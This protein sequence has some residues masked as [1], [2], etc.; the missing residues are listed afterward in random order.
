MNSE[1]ILSDYLVA[2][3]KTAISIMNASGWESGEVKPDMMGFDSVF[4]YIFDFQ[5]KWTWACSVP[6][7][8]F[9]EFLGKAFNLPQAEI[10]GLCGQLIAKWAVEKGVGLDPSDLAIALAS[11]I[12]TTKTYAL[13]ENA[14]KGNHFVVIRYGDVLRPFAMNGPDRHLVT[15]SIIEQSIQKVVAMDAKNHPEWMPC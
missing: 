14:V 10:V 3:K 2:K 9:F 13:T 15:S 6:K 11:Y 8:V 7:D 4:F 1:S 5:T 12:V